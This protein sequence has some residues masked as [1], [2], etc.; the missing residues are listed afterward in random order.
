MKNQCIALPNNGIGILLTQG[1]VAEIDAADWDKISLSSWQANKK[2]HTVYARNNKTPM[3]R[4]INGT[5]KGMQTDHIDCNGLNNRRA[6]L[7]TCTHHQNQMNRTSK[8]GSSQYKGVSFLKNRKLWYTSISVNN[9]SVR[10][11]F[12]RYEDDAARAYDAAAV[13]FYGEFA[14][15]NFTLHAKGEK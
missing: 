7:R 10:L 5:P 11:G 15:L 14:R 8:I 13:K 1:Y 12:F 9:K 6:N 3:H 2:S 4:L